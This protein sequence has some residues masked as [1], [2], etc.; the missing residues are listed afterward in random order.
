MGDPAGREPEAPAF[1][2]DTLRTFISVLSSLIIP[3]SGYPG[4]C[5]AFLLFLPQTEGLWS[6]FGSI[7][8]D[9]RYSDVF[10]VKIQEKRSDLQYLN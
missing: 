10:E 5:K 4:A 6:D 9:R 3:R 7:S 8:S 1:K 2:L